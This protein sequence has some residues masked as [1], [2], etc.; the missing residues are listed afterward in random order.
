M[1]SALLV[2]GALLL[3]PAPVEVT[4][5]ATSSEEEPPSRC[6]KRAKDKAK[7]KALDQ[8]GTEIMSTFMDLQTTKGGED[9]QAVADYSI[10][11]QQALVALSDVH[12]GQLQPGA[13]GSMTCSIRAKAQIVGR[14]KPDPGFN[15]DEFEMNKAGYFTGDIASMKIKVTRDA[16]LYILDKDEADNV[17]MLVPNEISGS[18]L[19]VK[20]NELVTFPDAKRDHGLELVAALPDGQNKEVDVIQI[21]AVKDVPDLFSVSDARPTK[22]GPY[23]AYKLGTMNRV[24]RRLASLER[25]SWT[26]AL[27]PFSIRRKKN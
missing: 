24:M 22:V 1:I 13:G 16:Y 15:F 20:A 23:S 9:F 8:I 21:I 2:A 18:S 14:G 19:H 11:L 26:M 27:M 4:A 6:Y 12:K 7:Q 25:K 10:Q 17:I 5:S 3:Q